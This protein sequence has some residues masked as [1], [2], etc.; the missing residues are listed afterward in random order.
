ML[1]IW[2]VVVVVPDEI[3]TACPADLFDA[4]STIRESIR[5]M[6]YLKTSDKLVLHAR[7]VPLFVA[8]L[9]VDLSL[10][11]ELLGPF[12]FVVSPDLLFAPPD[13]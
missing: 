12:M 2:I 13:S 5:Q 10:P 7:H 8:L 1:S 11:D 6:R 3:V 4:I 9:I